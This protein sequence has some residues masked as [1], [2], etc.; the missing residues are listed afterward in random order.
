MQLSVAASVVVGVSDVADVTP[1]PSV[2][3]APPDVALLPL[4][5]VPSVVVV[6]EPAVPPVEGPP[7]HPTSMKQIPRA[8]EFIRTVPS[9]ALLMSV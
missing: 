7:G 1:V 3:P 9:M 2:V 4:D 8:I 6:A 5:D